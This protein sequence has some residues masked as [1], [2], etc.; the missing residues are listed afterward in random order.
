MTPF[1]Q[2]PPV[3]PRRVFAR[4]LTPAIPHRRN[5]TFDNRDKGGYHYAIF[6]EASGRIN[7]A[8]ES[9]VVGAGRT[10]PLPFFMNCELCKHG[11]YHYIWQRWQ[12]W[13]VCKDCFSLLLHIYQHGFPNHSPHP[14]TIPGY[15]SGAE[16]MVMTGKSW[17]GLRDLEAQGVRMIRLH[18]RVFVDI[19]SLS[20]WMH[21]EGGK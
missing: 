10:Q 2:N 21:K 18:G 3:A 11:R 17:K 9:F 13:R 15:C 8:L 1:P 5:L 14:L 4:S 16:A 20:D 12:V 6:G 19:H 7:A